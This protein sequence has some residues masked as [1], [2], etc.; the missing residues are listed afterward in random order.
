MIQGLGLILFLFYVVLT[1]HILGF[2]PAASLLFCFGSLFFVVTLRHI[3]T[4]SYTPESE[5]EEI[6]GFVHG[7]EQA[8]QLSYWQVMSGAFEDCVF[9]APAL[10]AA[11]GPF[12]VSLAL[13]GIVFF[14]EAH[15]NYSRIFKL[16][17]ALWGLSAIL[18][19]GSF[20]LGTTMVAHGLHNLVAHFLNRRKFRKIVAELDARHPFW[21]WHDL[22]IIV[23]LYPGLTWA[24][25]RDLLSL[26]EE[27]LPGEARQ[28]KSELG[29]G[30][31]R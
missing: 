23:S 4:L 8:F 22:R 11:G 24:K 21:D 31:S 2:S 7:G 29:P 17:V 10:L 28:G 25:F 9:F 15:G 27:A 3:L 14:T 18:V 6:R 1:P 30:N 26:A 5:H 12:E 19:A 13:G 16:A 20:G